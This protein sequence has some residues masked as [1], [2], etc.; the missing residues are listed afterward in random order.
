MLKGSVLHLGSDMKYC[1]FPYLIFLA[2]IIALDKGYPDPGIPIV[3]FLFLH[4]NICYTAHWN[5][6]NETLPMSSIRDVFY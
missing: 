4:Q 1:V 3:I 2:L 6:L 5:C